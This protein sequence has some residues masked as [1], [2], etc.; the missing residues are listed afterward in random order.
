MENTI[1]CKRCNKSF[2]SEY[3]NGGSINHNNWTNDGYL[4][5]LFREGIDHIIK[6]LDMRADNV[7]NIKSYS[8]SDQKCIINCVTIWLKQNSH[9]AEADKVTKYFEDKEI[10]FNTI[11]NNSSEI[12]KMMY[13]TIEYN[14]IIDFYHDNDLKN[15]QYKFI[16]IKNIDKTTDAKRFLGVELDGEIYTLLHKTF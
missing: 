11:I 5:S 3:Y 13:Y 10:L 16:I 2:Y 4:G 15:K 6:K 1:K 12:K 7:C 9:A 8:V 14:I